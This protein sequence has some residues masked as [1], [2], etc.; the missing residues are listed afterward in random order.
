MQTEVSQ[1]FEVIV[2]TASLSKYADPLLDLLDKTRAVRIHIPSFPSA[3]GFSCHVALLLRAAIRA[4]EGDPHLP[5]RPC[6]SAGASVS[7]AL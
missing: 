5:L 7:S 3:C 2:F 6:G 1:K 4:A